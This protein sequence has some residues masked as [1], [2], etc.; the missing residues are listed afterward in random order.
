MFMDRLQFTRP[1]E[2]VSFISAPQTSHSDYSQPTSFVHCKTPP[3]NV[4][5]A[6]FLDAPMAFVL[7]W[8]YP[9]VGDGY[10][11]KPEDMRECSLAEKTRARLDNLQALGATV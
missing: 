4:P 1:A 7:D 2:F 10:F 5:A 3:E 8:R 11:T 6:G 9:G